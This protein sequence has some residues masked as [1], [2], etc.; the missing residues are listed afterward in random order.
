LGNPVI[1]L[2][3]RNVAAAI[4]APMQRGFQ[5]FPFASSPR[6]TETMRVNEPGALGIA[7]RT[8]PWPIGATP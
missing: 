3:R 8:G 7:A 4:I 2:E 6:L 1:A 5:L